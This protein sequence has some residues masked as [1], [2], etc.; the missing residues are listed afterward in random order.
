MRKFKRKFEELASQLE[1]DARASVEEHLDSIDG[2]LDMVRSEN[3]ALES[4]RD[5]VFRARVGDEI[6]RLNEAMDRIL[7]AVGNV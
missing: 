1:T 6:D 3:V 2:T 4:E 5:P 7:A